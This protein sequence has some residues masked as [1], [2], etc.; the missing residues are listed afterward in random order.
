MAGRFII[1]EFDDKN[2]AEAFVSMDLASDGAKVRAMF[3]RPDKYCQCPDKQRH[4]VKNWG[5][6]KRSGLYLCKRCKLPSIHH[7]QGIMGRLQYV[8][9]YNLLEGDDV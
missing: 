6:G 9:G 1:L 2:S 5:K 4:D 7:Q 8:F 3:M